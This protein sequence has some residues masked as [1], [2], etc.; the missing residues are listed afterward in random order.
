LLPPCSS[1]N[2]KDTRDTKGTQADQ[3]FT[4]QGYV[5]VPVRRVS[6][7]L[8]VLFG[9]FPSLATAQIFESIG[10]RAQ[11]MGGAFVALADDASLSWWNPAGLAGSALFSTILET[12]HADSSAMDTHAIALSVPSLAVS[13]YHLPLSGIRPVAS[14]VPPPADRKDPGGLN[15]F[16]ITVGQSIGGHLVLASTF[17]VLNG[18]DNTHPDLDIGAIGRFGHVRLGIA[19]KN[20]TKPSFGTTS[21]PIDLERQVRIGGAWTSQP[22]RPSTKSLTVDAD[23]TTAGTIAGDERHLAAGAEVWT[24]SRRIGARGGFSF[25]TIGASRTSGSVGLSLAIRRGTFLD[26]QLT[27]GSDDARRGWAFGIRVAF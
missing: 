2:H 5:S 11:G 24:A 8:L 17:K 25:N 16:G 13:Y 19:V 6:A 23:L 9:C 4:T 10:I 15:L 14:T 3:A 26:G 18:N 7:I 12:T 22:G 27:D 20:V 21:D 1:G